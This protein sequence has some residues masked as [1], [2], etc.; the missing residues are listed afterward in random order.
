MHS[1]LPCYCI[2]AALVPSLAT[3]FLTS[4]CKTS[5]CA[6]LRLLTTYGVRSLPSYILTS[7]AS[8][9][10]IRA[11]THHAALFMIRKHR[12]CVL[13]ALTTLRYKQ[14]LFDSA[15]IAQCCSALCSVPSSHTRLPANRTDDRLLV[16]TSRLL[17]H[18]HTRRGRCP[19]FPRRD[20]ISPRRT[21]GA[22][23]RVNI[24]FVSVTCRAP[25]SSSVL[26]D[27]V[28]MVPRCHAHL[29]P[30]AIGTH[31]VTRVAA[32]VYTSRAQ[33][34]HGAACVV[35]LH[36]VR[37]S[38]YYCSGLPSLYLHLLRCCGM[39]GCHLV[40]STILLPSRANETC[41]YLPYFPTFDY[42]CLPGVGGMC[43]RYEPQRITLYITVSCFSASR[44]HG[45]R[46]V[47]LCGGWL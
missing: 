40:F 6:F 23:H 13:P 10:T 46:A 44:C 17:P 5:C 30:L 20:I 18:S 11:P 42:L 7:F 16:C 43:L 47:L 33:T 41:L 25:L 36:Y 1:F 31:L 8:L 32:H 37:C 14:W 4:A 9:I 38:G 27:R 28:A 21:H 29:L 15:D 22:E 2:L 19:R 12:W 45:C 39:P 3:A 24:T 26:F 34:L 35:L